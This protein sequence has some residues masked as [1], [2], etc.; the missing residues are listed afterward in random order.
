MRPLC[1]YAPPGNNTG[2]GCHF[3]LEEIIPT[4]GSNPHLLHCRWWACREATEPPGKPKLIYWILKNSIETFKVKE[5]KWQV[6][7]ERGR[8][9]STFFALGTL[10]SSLMIW[11]Y[12]WMFQAFFINGGTTAVRDSQ[13]HNYSCMLCFYSEHEVESLIYYSFKKMNI[14]WDVNSQISAAIRILVH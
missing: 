3:L 9:S 1:P 10:R 14:K 8:D 13:Y 5:K 12:T 11:R 7:K 2:T 6:C 4:Q